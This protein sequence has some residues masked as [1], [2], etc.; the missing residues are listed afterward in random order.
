MARVFVMSQLCDLFC[1]SNTL[2]SWWKCHWLERIHLGERPLTFPPLACRFKISKHSDGANS[3]KS[4][5]EAHTISSSI[6]P[7]FIT[8]A[9]SQA[10]FI[11]Y[12]E[13]FSDL[14]KSYFHFYFF[15]NF[16]EKSPVLVV[17]GT[18]ARFCHLNKCSFILIDYIRLPS[19]TIARLI[20]CLAQYRRC[21]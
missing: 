13:I 2:L 12:Y 1:L 11:N 3:S 19:L 8:R 21:L 7:I 5:L 6:L 20:R 18:V 16:C 15:R 4:F 14:W 9:H 10:E 17:S